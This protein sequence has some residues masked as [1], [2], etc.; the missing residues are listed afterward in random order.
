MQKYSLQNQLRG[1][2][3]VRVSIPVQSPTVSLKVY[4]RSHSKSALI[5][6]NSF[7]DGSRKKKYKSIRKTCWILDI[8]DD[9]ISQLTLPIWSYFHS[10][11]HVSIFQIFY[12]WLRKLKIFKR[13]IK[14]LPVVLYTDILYN[15]PMEQLLESCK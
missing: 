8:F 9:T 13:C 11:R 12:V 7:I 6:R 4:W 3:S 10:F 1:N 2:L 5:P 15:R 14:T